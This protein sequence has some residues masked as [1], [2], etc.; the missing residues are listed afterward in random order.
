MMKSGWLLCFILA[1]SFILPGADLVKNGQ[2]NACIALEKDP[3]P[4]LQLAAEEIALYFRKITGRD[5]LPPDRQ[6]ADK[7]YTITLAVKNDPALGHEGYRI[8]GS[9]QGV[10]I[11]G[12]TPRAVLYGTYAF[13]EEFFG[14]RWLA[15]GELYEYVP[16]RKNL[17]LPDNIARVAKPEFS[18]RMVKFSSCNWNSDLKDTWKFLIRNRWQVKG[19]YRARN[20]YCR[21][22]AG[23][24]DRMDVF[25]DGGGHCLLSLVPDKLFEKHPEYFAL[26]KGKRIRQTDSKGRHLSQPCTS[27][28]EVI[29]LAAAGIIEYFDKA[30]ANSSYLIGNNDIQVWCECRNCTALDT[31][32]ERTENRVSTRFF[33]FINEVIKIVRQKHPAARIYAWGYQNYRFAPNG[34]MP[35]RTLRINLCDHQRCYRHS[36][37]DKNCEQN[38]IFR[39][40]F[41]SWR[42]YDLPVTE[43]GYQE[44]L[45]RSGYFYLPIEK[46]I[47]DDITYFK[48][49][50]VDG[51]E[52]ITSPPDG[53]YGRH[54]PP[55]RAECLKNAMYCLWPSIYICGKMLWNSS[56]DQEAVWQDAGKHFYG[57]AWGV[58]QEYRKL[59]LQ[60]Y[61]ETSG[62]IIYSHDPVDIGRALQKPGVEKKL[63]ALLEQAQ[64]IA[65]EDPDK[66]ISQRL[67][68]EKKYFLDTWVKNARAFEKT[69]SRTSAGTHTDEKISID[70]VLAE[71][72]W[73]QAA[74]IAGFP[75][76]VSPPALTADIFAKML[77]SEK[78]IYLA[79]SGTAPAAGEK[80]IISFPDQKNLNLPPREY[81]LEHALLFEKVR[82]VD[83]GSIIYELKIPR[84]L[85]D[86]SLNAAGILLNVRRVQS[87][88]TCAVLYP[89]RFGCIALG[90]EAV[91]N[92]NLALTA[93]VSKN[94]KSI[95]SK[96]FPQKWSVS[97]KSVAFKAG[98]IALNGVLYQYMQVNGGSRGGSINVAISCLPD[99]NG[100]AYIRPYLSLCTRKPGDRRPFRH[101]LKKNGK[102]TPVKNNGVYNYTFDFAPGEK[103]YFYL[104]GGNVLIENITVTYVEKRP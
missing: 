1:F 21:G 52:Y 75:Q 69:Q 53:T 61:T 14:V 29:K 10:T 62:H 44:I 31:P 8:Q 48:K 18:V 27:N 103:G 91:K 42:K 40:M 23:D 70:G 65:A 73:Q 35:D 101:E 63:L 93:A 11:A 88:Q 46:V 20:A 104:V 47:A 34:V 3:P 90:S 76:K 50:G 32:E 43:R 98:K 95:K 25:Y 49:I 82:K 89:R 55:A 86:S 7:C 66:K 5:I 41:M 51:Y 17:S 39:D 83:N 28:P 79:L 64:K 9:L 72:S 19:N 13:I 71:K 36:L 96:K 57:Q 6:M 54:I 38:D 30:P 99:R 78:Y 80:W 97:G 67:A 92:G 85:V 59:L 2:V 77:W 84:G 68:L 37:L 26:V 12:N 58:M 102:N 16:V 45:L 100:K 22:F 56:L 81:D 24:Y 33:T 60:T 4:P 15:P 87:G 74:F 94:R